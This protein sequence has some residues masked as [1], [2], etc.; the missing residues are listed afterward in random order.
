VAILRA[1]SDAGRVLGASRLA[2]DLEAMGIDVSQRTVRYHLAELDE[3]GF[4]RSRG[5]RGREITPLGEQ[6]LANAFVAEKVGFIASRIDELTYQMTF[7]LRRRTG[8]IVLNVSTIPAARASEAVDAMLAVFRAGLGMGT[9]VLVGRAGQQFKRLRVAEDEFAVGT[10]CSVTLNGILL[11]AGIPT[12]SR[13]GGLL[14]IVDGQP[15]RFTEMIEYEGTSLDPLEIFISGHMTSVGEAARTG[16]GIVGASFREIPAVSV[17]HVRKLGNRLSQVG[18][19]GL[20][21]VGKPN[22]PLFEVPVSQGR[23]GLVVVGGLNPIAA[24]EEVGIHTH[25]KALTGMWD[26]E[27]LVPCEQLPFLVHGAATEGP[28]P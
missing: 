22:R 27:E 4:T 9:Q 13:F 15:A 19:G 17:P 24:V 10:V 23:A 18:L 5:K 7:S 6:E 1:L 14:E 11:A 21:M 25:S 12:T 28:T 8:S 20:L 26:F 3:K 2:R 16:H